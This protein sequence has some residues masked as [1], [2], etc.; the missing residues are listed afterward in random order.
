MGSVHARGT[1]LFSQC[2][3]FR[4]LSVEPVIRV[5]AFFQGVQ[6]EHCLT[7]AR[8]SGLRV[9]FRPD[10]RAAAGRQPHYRY[11][12]WILRVH[13]IP[14]QP[15]QHVFGADAPPVVV[16]VLASLPGA[17][18]APLVGG[19]SAGRRGAGFRRFP[20]NQP[21]Q[22]GLAVGLGA[23]LSL[24]TPLLLPAH[25]ALAAHEP[26]HCRHRR[27]PNCAA[28]RDI[29][30]IE[31]RGRHELHGLEPVV[32][33]APAAAGACVPGIFRPDRFD[34]V[35]AAVL[36]RPAFR[37]GAAADSQHLSGR[38]C[39]HLRHRRRPTPGR[40]GNS[41]IPRENLLPERVSGFAV[42]FFGTVSPLFSF[43]VSAPSV[44]DLFPLPHQIFKRRY[45]PMRPVGGLH[46][47]GL[48]WQR[49]TGMVRLRSP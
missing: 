37:R 26:V 5:F 32:I 22:R 13:L 12:L 3:E 39:L 25:R 41:A 31:P 29:G 38:D 15:A 20:G 8:L 33:A 24:R 45:F 49:K 11:Q 1:A 42:A 46:G 7:L 6:S 18:A 44:H 21:D 19:D 9:S 35:D 43:L 17:Q 4:A 16:A 40:A 2:A 23:V 47:G 36:G 10:R 27:H 34:S 30:A 48:F 14:D 28:G